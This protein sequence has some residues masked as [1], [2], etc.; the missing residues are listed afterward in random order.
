[1]NPVS[2]CDLMITHATTHDIIDICGC[3]DELPLHPERRE[4]IK[5]ALS[6]NSIWIARAP[7]PGEMQVVGYTICQPAAFFGHAYLSLVMTHPSWR[8]QG[9]AQQLIE[10]VLEQCDLGKS[11]KLF[12]T[13]RENNLPMQRLLEKLGFQRSGSVQHVH[14]NE[15]AEL[16]FHRLYEGRKE[17]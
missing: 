13:V 4:E 2:P 6:H 9:V 14:A 12:C 8:H 3:D 16:V 10:R 5:R 15:E 17:E 1:M 7:G 11:R